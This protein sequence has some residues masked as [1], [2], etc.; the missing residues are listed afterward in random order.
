[1]RGKKAPRR[2]V[3]ADTQYQN[4]NVARLVNKLMRDGKKSVAQKVV[5]DCFALIKEKTKQDPLEIF[6]GAL[7]NVTP[8]VEVKGRRIGGANYQIPIPVKGDRKLTLALRWILDAS[9]TRKGKPM[10]EKLAMEILDAYKN[11]G[12]AIKKRADVQRMAEANRAFAHFA[13]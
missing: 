4:A 2:K 8:L 6:D 11:E 3:K 1:M 5:Y 13:R 12:S 9:R 10:R 7:K